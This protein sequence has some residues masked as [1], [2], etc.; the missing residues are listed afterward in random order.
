MF[1]NPDQR[2]TL[3]GSALFG[4]EAKPLPYILAQ[5]NLLLHGLEGPQIAYGNTWE[6]R[7]S[8]IDYSERV[9]AM[10]LVL[11]ALGRFS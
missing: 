4:Q 6:R 11:P 2:R 10:T 5:M 1:R 9:D 8:G 3:Q 7:I